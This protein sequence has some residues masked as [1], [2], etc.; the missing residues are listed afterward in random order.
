MLLRAVFDDDPTSVCLATPDGAVI[1]CNAA[2]AALFGFAAAG[3]ARGAR[4]DTLLVDGAAWRRAAADASAGAPPTRFDAAGR[5]REGHVL[6]VACRLRPAADPELPGAVLTWFTDQTEFAQAP[7]TT[8]GARLVRAI[9]HD[10]GNM[11]MVIRGFAEVLVRELPEGG[12]GRGWVA[13]IRTASD[14]AAVLGEELLAGAR[15][16]DPALEDLSPAAAVDAVLP[17]V[18]RVAGLG[19]EVEI[20]GPDAARPIRTNRDQ[21]ESVLLSLVSLARIDRPK[22]TR[23]R[24]AMSWTDGEPSFLVL[25]VSGAEPGRTW[26]A[27]FP[28]SP[29]SG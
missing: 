20:H 14:R 10:L 7:R 13:Q 17:L 26:E 3:Q 8:T 28:T 1:E 18:R 11:M 16:H 19:V 24:V 21:F 22:D 2:F 6:L 29:A 27:R 12:R 15:P 4:L 23:L 5:T 9:G 25:S